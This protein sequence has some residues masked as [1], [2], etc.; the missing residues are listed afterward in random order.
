MMQTAKHTET[1]R[2]NAREYH[3]KR[4]L[5]RS[6]NTQARKQM[7]RENAANTNVTASSNHKMKEPQTTKL[8]HQKPLHA[9][10]TVKKSH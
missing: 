6:K 4:K 1:Q 5:D 7:Q 10:S 8:K 2:T 3:C 9:P